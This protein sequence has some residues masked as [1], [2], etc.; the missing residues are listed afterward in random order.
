MVLPIRVRHLEIFLAVAEAGSMQRAARACHLSQPA[1]TKLIR[2]L[3]GIFGVPLLER[4]RRG[5]TVT[6]CGQALVDRSR[7]ILND[8]SETAAELSTIDSGVMGRVRVGALPVAEETI[9]PNTLLAVR[10]KV[11]D[12][13]V[14]IEEGSLPSL[15]TA[16]R[17]GEVDCVVGRLYPGQVDRDLHVEGLLPLPVVLV[18]N[19]THS[20]ARRKR[21]SWS[22]LS[23][24]PW[25]LPQKS[26]PIR[27][28]IDAEFVRAGLRPLAPSIESTSSTIN[29]ALVSGTD[30]IAPMTGATALRY[31]GAK[32]L[33][34]LPI[35]WHDA[36]PEVGVITRKGRLSRAVLTFLRVLR[37]ACVEM[38][39]NAS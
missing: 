6:E 36:L 25:I 39:R 1:I 3:E 14:Q 30:M 21:V 8:V 15:L 11:P 9:L 5:V 18:V 12:L 4:G 19:Q 13:S 16:L 38:R 20:L 34:A 31:I 7:L 10:K 29:Y 22:D 17:R 26:A 23:R 35:D 32:M 28:I 27:A 33:A 24:F 2:E 37:E